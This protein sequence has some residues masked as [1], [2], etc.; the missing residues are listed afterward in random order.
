MRF[1]DFLR[2]TV[3]LSAG[4]ATMLAAVTLASAGAEG[5]ETVVYVSVGWWAVAVVW[6][7][8]VGR[9]A[10][11]SAPIARLLASARASHALPEQRSGATLVNRL[12]PLLASTISAGVLGFLAP[13]IPGMATGFAVIWALLWRRQHGAVAAIEERDGVRFYVEHTSP[14]RR[15]RLIRTPGFG[16]R[17][18]RVDGAAQ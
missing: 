12:W 11:P 16:G 3:L 7:G 9:A 13:Q 2:T 10:R 18:L 1:V 4:A 14:L 17:F 5:E 8:W 15:I 6:G